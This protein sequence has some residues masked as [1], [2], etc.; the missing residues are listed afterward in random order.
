MSRQVRA[1]AIVIALAAI[2]FVTY[3]HYR[4]NLVIDTG[5]PVT[6]LV[7]KQAIPKGTPLR[8]I[9]SKPL[10]AAKTFRPSQV[11]TDA[12]PDDPTALRGMVTV[13]RIHAGEQLTPADFGP[14]TRQYLSVP[15]RRLSRGH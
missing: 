8:I 11:V 2:A 15:T 14:S 4:G 7:A 13:K 1:T 5:P 10:Y 12:F 6:V 3:R 9:A